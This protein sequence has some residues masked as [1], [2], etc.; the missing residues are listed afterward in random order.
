[1]VYRVLSVGFFVGFW[2]FES[3]FSLSKNKGA[4]ITVIDI[5]VHSIINIQQMGQA[6]IGTK[7]EELAWR[8]SHTDANMKLMNKTDLYSSTER[9]F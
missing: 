7:V 4:G 5:K 9:S 8:Q 2:L 6:G 3:L 1:M